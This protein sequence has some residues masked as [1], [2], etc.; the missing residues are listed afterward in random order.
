LNG[1]PLADNEFLLIQEISRRGDHTQRSLSRSIGLSLGT[2]NLLVRRLTRKGLIKARQLDWKRTQYLLTLKGAVEKARKSF[3]Y[4][5]YTLRIF[6]QIQTNIASA[7]RREHREGRRIFHI[8]AQDELASLLSD[9]VS[10]LDLK[11]VSFIFHDSFADVPAD[12]ERVLTATLE[13]PPHGAPARRFVSL[14]DFD[15][16]DFRL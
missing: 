10:G 13:R 9:S 5:Q 7:L 15:D 11:G 12:G 3:A 8:V 2:T 14:V 16:I 4:A 1:S 6:N